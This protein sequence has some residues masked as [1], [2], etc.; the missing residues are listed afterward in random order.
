M[1]TEFLSAITA[2]SFRD[3]PFPL[4]EVLE[5][6]LFYPA[7][8]TDGT[9]IRHWLPGILSFVYV[10]SSTTEAEHDRVLIEAPP[11]GYSVLGKRRLS[12][13]DLTPN[14]WSPMPPE[15][16]EPKR[17]MQ[18][19]K[20]SGASPATAFA[21]WT[22]FERESHLTDEHGPPRFSLLFLRAEGVAAYQAL[23]ISNKVCPKAIA[24][25]RPGTGFGGNFSNFEEVLLKTLQSNTSGMPEHLLQWH[26]IRDNA[27]LPEAPWNSI[28]GERII[29][30]LRKD[31]DPGFIVSV[32]PL[33]A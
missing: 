22:V 7:S 31:N 3:A 16:I 28:Y 26:H 21:T 18:L 17:Y 19:M 25:I 33:I 11:K 27:T 10:D 30:P 2:S 8:G 32:Y 9:P 15:G 20:M 6:S 1:K 29:G 14:G 5:D 4:D 12:P 24:I 13:T 23:Y